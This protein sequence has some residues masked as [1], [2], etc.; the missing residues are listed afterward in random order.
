MARASLLLDIRR[1]VQQHE[2]VRL[3][4]MLQDGSTQRDVAAAFGVTQHAQSVVSRAWNRYL[5]TGDYVR[6]PGQGRLRCPTA[7]QDRCIYGKCHGP[8][9]TATTHIGSRCACSGGHSRFG[10]V[11]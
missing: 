2:V 9:I 3:I 1:H 11:W 10:L 5:A 4:Q 6:R 8:I 7:R